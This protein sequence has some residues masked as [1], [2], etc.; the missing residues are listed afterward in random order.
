[1]SE[2]KVGQVWR[3]K[4]KRRERTVEILSVGENEVHALIVGTENETSLKLD[5]FVKR[6]E[7]IEDKADSLITDDELSE[8][9]EEVEAE[10]PAPKHKTR[11]QWLMAAVK[12]LTKSL[13][14]PLG[15]EVPEVRVSVGWPGGRGKKQ[16]VVGQCFATRVTTD[17][18]AQIFVSPVV[19]EPYEVVE[20]LAHE[21]IHAIDDCESGHKKGFIKIAKQVGFLAP[22]K[23]TPAS[24]ELRDKLTAI[25]EKL[26]TYPHAAIRP[27]DRPKV[28]K[29][30][31]ILVESVDCDSCEDGY[32]VRMTSKWIEEVGLPLCPHGVEM[33]LQ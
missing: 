19:V 12:E 20:T 17:K 27:E 7:L 18:V 21:I 9:V 15:L 22:W 2:V 26:G 1:M 16:G 10:K 23:Q 30:Y 4:D 8:A 29:T 11:E 25:A 31:M 14:G 13:F 32:K 3:D 28:Q 6:W 24:D 5:R 33:E